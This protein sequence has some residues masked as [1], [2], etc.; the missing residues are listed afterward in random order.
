VRG[1]VSTG[2]LSEAEPFGEQ[3]GVFRGSLFM[4]TPSPVGELLAL[5]VVAFSSV[6]RVFFPRHPAE[7]GYLIVLSVAIY[8]V[9]IGLA[10][11]VRNKGRSHEAVYVFSSCTT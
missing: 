1:A 3:G 8:M 6:R 10:V 5:P 4:H 2:Y 9:Y 7:V 11:R